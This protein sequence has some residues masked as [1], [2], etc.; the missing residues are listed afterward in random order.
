MTAKNEAAYMAD[1]ASLTWI[2]SHGFSDWLHWGEYRICRIR[3]KWD[4]NWPIPQE[5]IE[6]YV[7][8]SSWHEAAVL[9]AKKLAQEA[10]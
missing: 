6:V 2:H 4:S 10:I 8:A 7:K 3:G 5:R 1:L 9:A